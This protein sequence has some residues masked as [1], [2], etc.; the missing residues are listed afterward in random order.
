MKPDRT[1]LPPL[2]S[3]VKW[4]HR[5]APGSFLIRLL[6][7]NL[8][9]TRNAARYVA[10][11]CRQ[12]PGIRGYAEYLRDAMAA[13]LGGRS[14]ELVAAIRSRSQPIA[15]APY[16]TPRYGCVLCSGGVRIRQVAHDAENLCLRHPGQLVWV[17]PG[18][19]PSNQ[20]I[21]RYDGQIAHAE[22]LHRRYTAVRRFNP[23]LTARAS[24]MV[25]D[26]ARL[27]HWAELHPVL[28]HLPLE[29]RRAWETKARLALYPAT[30]ALAQILTDQ[31]NLSTWLNPALSNQELRRLFAVS[32]LRTGQFPCGIRDLVERMLLHLRPLRDRA[33][34]WNDDDNWRDAPWLWQMQLAAV[35]PSTW[36]ASRRA[37]PEPIDTGGCID[38]DM[39]H[40]L[41]RN[42]LAIEE[43]DWQENGCAT[44]WNAPATLEAWYICQSCNSRYQARTRQRA[45]G[46]GCS[47]C[48]SPHL[49][50]GVNDL[51]T[52]HPEIAAQWDPTPGANTL[53]P[54][55]ITQYSSEEMGWVCPEWG[56][57]WRATVR[58]R[59]YGGKCPHC[60]RVRRVEERKGARVLQPGLNDL[61]TL[62]PEIAAQWDAKPGM[63]TKT[64]HQVTTGSMHRA[65]WV[66]PNCTGRWIAPIRRR[67]A[68]S[69]CPYCAGKKVLLGHNDL[70]TLRPTLAQE[71]DHTT[72]ANGRGPEQV[73][74]SSGYK[75]A[76]VC[77]ICGARWNATVNSRTQGNGCPYC[78]GVQIW[79]GRND[80]ASQR[81]EVA[82]EWSKS[83][84][85]NSRTPTEVAL[86][87]HYRATWRCGT[88]GH[89]WTARVSER[90]RDNGSG[91][92][93]C[94]RRREPPSTNT[95]KPIP[96]Q[97]QRW[98]REP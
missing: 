26:N 96:R 62:R 82:A 76:W 74:V 98:L 18:T 29:D 2:A 1:P 90:T 68:G 72:G 35:D 97:V 28:R 53:T 67:V 85:T 46:S 89:Q 48:H 16:P 13:E 77:R 9:D 3:Q 88:C 10:R 49:L 60:E 70:A 81:P 17:G 6:A 51:K 33:A 37:A 44:P 87:S 86:N 47:N 79:V 8:I 42:P 41:P 69:G 91:C 31:R 11:L 27:S 93:A 30:V 4:G 92:P 7:A 25:R 22:R 65:W 58:A 56:H 54:E 36:H 75:A 15:S 50:P 14:P 55:Q 66:C 34:T 95:P 21:V 94:A 52:R 40:L 78:A 61:A 84:G 39:Y 71:W 80:L 63:N 20:I 57:Q 38:S 5:E 64:P 45:R 23:D 83:R 24:E 12:A 19:D 59:T 32:L 73:T 43:W